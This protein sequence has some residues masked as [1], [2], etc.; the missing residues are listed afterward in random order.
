MLLKL[1]CP[2]CIAMTLLA[3]FGPLVFILRRWSMVLLDMLINVV[4][5]L[6]DILWVCVY[7]GLFRS[8]HINVGVMLTVFVVVRLSCVFWFHVLVCFMC[9]I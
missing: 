8:E 9:D 4:F 2:S 7:I 5:I 3:V 1:S 6:T